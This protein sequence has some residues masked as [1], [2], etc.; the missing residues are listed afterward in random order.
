MLD[1]LA[2]AARQGKLTVDVVVFQVPWRFVQPLNNVRVGLVG[3]NL[4]C[5]L[6]GC[7]R[8][9]AGSL[10]RRSVL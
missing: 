1:R 8:K 4:Q 6:K 9:A 10:R 2:V 3:I 7:A 5:L